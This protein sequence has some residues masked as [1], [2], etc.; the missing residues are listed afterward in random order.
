MLARGLHL[1]VPT[2]PPPVAN[3]VADWCAHE[4][5]VTRHRDLLFWN[6]AAF[7]LM[8][9]PGRGVRDDH[10]LILR[11]TDGRKAVMSGIDLEFHFQ[12]W[13]APELHEV[14]WA[15]IPSRSALGT[16]N[17]LMLMAKHHFAEGDESPVEISRSMAAAPM[18]A[19]GMNSPAGAFRS[20]R[21]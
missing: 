1:T 2:T 12:R 3:R 19:L 8:L 11:L 21:P 13:I 14:Q 15:P 4:F 9:V 20:L 17:D 10:D 7:L 5:T 6:T 16:M 18:S